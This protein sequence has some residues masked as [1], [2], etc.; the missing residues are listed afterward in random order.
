MVQE[1]NTN[2]IEGIINDNPIT[3]IKFSA[4]WCPTCKPVADKYEALSDEVDA[5]VICCATNV[6]EEPELTE[7]FNIRSIP[8]IIIFVKGQETERYTGSDCV[9]KAHEFIKTVNL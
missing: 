2:N 7:Q 6:D 4:E 9:E 1:I 5:E 8:T 3:C